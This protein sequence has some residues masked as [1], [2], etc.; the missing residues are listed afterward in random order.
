M[1]LS[2]TTE[3]ICKATLL[4]CLPQPQYHTSAKSNTAL[5]AAG[6]VG[7]WQLCAS[8]WLGIRERAA[9]TI[10]LAIS[11]KKYC[12]VA[13]PSTGKY[14]GKNI[15]RPKGKA[16]K[17]QNKQ[18]QQKKIQIQYLPCVSSGYL[19]TVKIVELNIQYLSNKYLS[20]DTD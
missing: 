4:S 2:K 13:S 8:S 11:M 1:Q 15:Y 3:G 19:I 12:S 5:E 7:N 14:W 10:F 16:E 6:G 17:K 9:E 20:F 18:Q